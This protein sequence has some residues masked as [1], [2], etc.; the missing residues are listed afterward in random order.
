MMTGLIPNSKTNNNAILLDETVSPMQI[1]FHATHLAILMGMERQSSINSIAMFPV[2]ETRYQLISEK[3]EWLNLLGRCT[4]D[5][6]LVLNQREGFL[7]NFLVDAKKFWLSNNKGALRSGKWV[8]TDAQG[9]EHPFEAVASI[10]KEHPILLVNRITESYREIVNI[11]QSAR[12]NAI[13]YEKT[14]RLVYQDFLTGLYNRRGFL[15]HSEEHLLV[16][17]C[18]HL[19]VT[20]ACIDLDRLKLINDT[21][22]HKVGDQVIINAA[23]LLKKIFRK[24]DIL[25]RVGGDEFFALMTDMDSEEIINFNARLKNTINDW[26]AH[27]EPHFQISLSIG[28]ASDDTHLKSL[29]LLV[30]QAD[31][32]MYENK[33]SKYLS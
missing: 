28:L 10:L 8:Q 18:K 14:E 1:S 32:N 19:P 20:V 30:S 9:I 13:G 33:Q 5:Q 24:Q 6:Q 3:P 17:R 27:Q 2:S 29:D 4:F 21:Y 12:E 23:I 22:G 31:A 15:L 16:A 25:A 26:N 11:L 7:E